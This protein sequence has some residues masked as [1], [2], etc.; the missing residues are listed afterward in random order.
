LK[1]AVMSVVS[2]FAS[3]GFWEEQVTWGVVVAL[4]GPAAATTPRSEML[5]AAADMR[6]VR[7]MCM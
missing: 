7:D 4:A 6:D 1:A 3:P 2:F 5:A